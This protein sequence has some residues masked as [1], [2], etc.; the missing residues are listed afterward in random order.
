VVVVLSPPQGLSEGVLASALARTWDLDVGSLNYQPV[1]FGSHHWDGVDATG[2]RWWVTVDDLERK[3]VSRLE[4]YG[5]A[6]DRLHAAIGAAAALRRHGRAFAVAPVPGADGRFLARLDERY[7]IALYPYLDGRRFPWGD[8]S[9][10]EHRR[11]TLDMVLGV[12]TAPASVRDGLAADDFGVA[13][14]DELESALE[15]GSGAPVGGPYARAM[16]EL[17]RTHAGSIRR[18]LARYQDLV[19]RARTERTVLT[20]GEPHAANTMLTADGWVLIDW[21]TAL[22][23]PPE[24][25]LWM[26]DP[27]DGSVLTAYAEATGHAPLVAMV[28]LYRLRWTLTD[29]AVEVVRFRRPHDG[30]TEDDAAWDILT[31]NVRALD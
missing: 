27:G 11:A 23:A 18:H 28:D 15:P 3:R 29:I 2:V 22:V 16:I 13:H 26:L 12:H 7:A 31:S 4:P 10:N 5:V 20:H 9:T 17:I 24:R 19:D 14:L 25:D 1:G 8:F 21:D 6:F 30:N